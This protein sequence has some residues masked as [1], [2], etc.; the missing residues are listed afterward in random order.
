MWGKQLMREKADRN[1]EIDLRNSSPLLNWFQNLAS[2]FCS[3]YWLLRPRQHWQNWQKYL[4]QLPWANRRHHPEDAQKYKNIDEVICTSREQRGF[5]GRPAGR[6]TRST[7]KGP[8]CFVKI[9]QEDSPT[10]VAVLSAFLAN[11][12]RWV[13][14]TCGN[15]HNRVPTK[16]NQHEQRQH[17][18]LLLNALA[19]TYFSG[20]LERIG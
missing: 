6:Y 19:K 2:I 7:I 3:T 10:Q 5:T 20:E 11:G 8:V 12:R 1:E 17:R 4:G 16:N 13:E 14:I 9:S 18:A 15:L